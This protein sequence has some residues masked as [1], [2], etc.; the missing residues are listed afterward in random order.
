MSDTGTIHMGTRGRKILISL[1]LAMLCVHVIA[2]VKFGSAQAGEFLSDFVQM[3]FGLMLVPLALR[4]ANRSTGVGRHYWRL[5]ALAYS[6]WDVAQILAT[7]QDIARTAHHMQ[8]IGFLFYFWYVPIG[9]ALFLDPESDSISLDR[10]AFVDLIQGLLFLVTAYVYF[11]LISAGTQAVTDLATGL[12]EPYLVVHSLIALAFVVRAGLARGVARRFLGRMGLFLLFSCSVDALYY[13]GP[14]KLLRTGEWFDLLWTILL[15]IPL[16]ITITWSEPQTAVHK[17]DHQAKSKS[18]L[19][20]Q[21]FSLVFPALILLM[22]AQLSRSKPVFASSVLVASFACS[23]ARLLLTQ[24]RLLVAQEAL[25]REATHDGLT[26]VWNHAGILGILDRELLRAERDV[27]AVGIMMVD[28]DTFKAINDCHGHASG[29]AVLR[30]L[31]AEM[32]IILRSYDSLGRY[33]GEEFLV[34]APGCGMPETIELAERIRA[35]VA[36]KPVTVKSGSIPVTISIGVTASRAEV[37]SAERLL[38]EADTALYLAKGTGRNRVE[39]YAES[40][41]EQG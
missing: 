37:F 31:A 1:T 24:K 28:V 33:G 20:T 5:T 22:A 21:S 41:D 8:L 18:Q 19:V 15:I 7:V 10:S 34:V 25:R 27:G 3:A 32:G 13:Y 26:S 11:F 30:A 17:D 16:L 38:Q 39:A 29:D 36:E 12:R 2:I 9:M 23:S 40:G 6:L 4:A 14:G 35:H